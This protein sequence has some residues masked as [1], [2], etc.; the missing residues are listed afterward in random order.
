MK[1][2]GIGNLEVK[3]GVKIIEEEVLNNI[4]EYLKTGKFKKISN[5]SYMNAFTAI[6]KLA[7]KGD[8]N[9][10]KLLDYHNRIIEKYIM[11]CKIYLNLENYDN[12]INKFL[13]QVEKIYFLIYWMNM[14]FSYLDRFYTRAKDKISLAH[15]AMNIFKSKY[16]DEI[17][18]DIFIEVDKLINEDRNGN[19]EPRIKIKK[20]L[21]ILKDFELVYPKIIKI[22]DEG[23]DKNKIIW[24]NGESFRK[25]ENKIEITINEQ[26]LWFNEYF[27]EDTKKYLEKKVNKDLLNMSFS[28]YILAQIKYLEEESERLN[29]YINPKYHKKI[30]EINYQY[31][32]INALKE[33]GSLNIYIKNLFNNEEYSQLINISKLSKLIPKDLDP[34]PPVFYSYIKSK[35][36][37]KFSNENLKNEQTRFIIEVIKFKKEMD[38][39][40][41]EHFRNIG[42]FEEIKDKGLNLIFQKDTFG[43]LLVNYVDYCMRKGF[44][45]NSPE[46]IENTLNDII[47]FFHYLNSRLVFQVE[48]NKK[49]TERLLNN[50]SLSIL[51]EKKLISKLEQEAGI[52]YVSKMKEMIED[53]EKNKTNIELYKSLNHKGSPNGIKMEVTVI[54]QECWKIN[55]NLMEKITIPK[56]LS[57]CLEDYENFYLNKYKGHKLI[58][59]L[60]LSKIGI[61]YLYLNQKYFSISTLPQ[62]LI[63]LLLEQNQ[64]LSLKAISELLGCNSSII[65]NDIP[66]LIYNPIFNPH[67][68]TDK[69]IIKVTFNEE[70]QLFKENDKIIINKDFN[71]S[72]IRFSTIPLKQKQSDS[73]KKAKELEESEI[74]KRYQNNILQSTITRIMKSKI[75]QKTTHFW[76]VAETRKQIDLFKAQPQQIKENIEKLIE[77]GVIIRTDYSSNCYEYNA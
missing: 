29:E 45:G 59:C 49:M 34:I 28:E 40:I 50:I 4:F 77:K 60:G 2:F 41:Q 51:N 38:L 62:L 24:I 36:E 30:N 71:Y 9:C 46:E 23:G 54:S 56:F 35:Y 22:N 26:D 19:K 58:W 63:L 64:E 10:A 53:L 39:F 67:A 42:Y 20:I 11:E 66:G 43:K 70:K 15:G 7:D 61:E 6:N 72:K 74:I 13:E 27:I 31:L 3:D 33:Y 12:F 18:N 5:D 25:N 21:N 68:R 65:I 75:G 55:Q 8:R 52:S 76:L 17:K 47:G 69:G 73:E 16:F 14:I 48:L 1:S 32:I 57:I 37:E 44:K